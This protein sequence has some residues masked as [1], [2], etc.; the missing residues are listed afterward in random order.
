M[1]YLASRG[2]ILRRTVY[3]EADRIITFLSSDYGKIHTIAKGVRKSKSKLAGGIELFSVSELHF[4]KG[5]HDIDTLVS[6]R[7]IRHFGNIVRNLERT[8]VA[9]AMLKSAHK[10][11]ED[12]AG[13]EY[14]PV[15]FESLAALDEVKIPDM[16]TEL[17]FGMRMLQ[18]QGHVPEFSIDHTGQA[19]QP[20]DTFIFDYETVAFRPDPTG[21]FNQNHLKV[22]KLLAYNSP[23]AV[24]KVQ[25]IAGYCETLAPL[26]RSLRQ[27]YVPE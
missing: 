1:K 11:I 22:L 8:N 20:D 13:S 10:T 17:S 23:Q 24:A 9:Y 19:L 26:V 3:G 2:I 4:I 18:L 15:L 7:L 5:K 21:S 16:V 6:T 14:F 25:G 12:H 27:Q